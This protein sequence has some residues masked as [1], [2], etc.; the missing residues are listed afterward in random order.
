M[1]EM[2]IYGVS[3]D[4]VGKEPIVLLKTADVHRSR[5]TSSRSKARTRARSRCAPRTAVTG[6]S[7]SLLS[8]PS[9]LPFR[10]I[11]DAGQELL[12]PLGGQRPAIRLRQVLE[13]LRLPLRVEEGDPA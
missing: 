1:H 3:F 9:Q 2:H 12:K 5:P 10:Q 4:I 13:H 11:E 6:L 8:A 7:L